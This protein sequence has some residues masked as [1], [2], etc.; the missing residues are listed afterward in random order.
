MRWLS[1]KKLR[2]TRKMYR[3]AKP[4]YKEIGGLQAANFFIIAISINCF[5]SS[6]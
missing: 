4:G 3:K 6:L 1:G 5:L 2:A